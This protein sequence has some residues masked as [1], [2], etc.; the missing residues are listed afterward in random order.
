MK[1]SVFFHLRF[2]EY[3]GETGYEQILLHLDWEM[4]IIYSRV[5]KYKY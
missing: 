2:H 1:H 5:T 4:D 3:K